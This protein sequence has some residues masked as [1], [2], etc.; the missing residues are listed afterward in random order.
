MI[1]FITSLQ[2]SSFGQS[3][4]S[5]LHVHDVLN[6]VRLVFFVVINR[7]TVSNIIMCAYH[8]ANDGNCTQNNKSVVSHIYI[9]QKICCQMSLTLS[10]QQLSLPIQ[11]V[12]WN[13]CHLVTFSRC[14]RLTPLF[15]L[16]LLSCKKQEIITCQQNN[17][18]P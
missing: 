9:A 3:S 17:N 11:R 8:D 4:L 14:R 6:S 13:R 18:H 5:T 2:L 16:S 7:N 12:K 1:Y 10:L 15:M